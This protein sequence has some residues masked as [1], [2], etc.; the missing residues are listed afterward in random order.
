MARLA[1]PTIAELTSTYTSNSFNGFG[2]GI[3]SK[4][5][6][7]ADVAGTVTGVRIGV[8]DFGTDNYIEVQLFKRTTS[9]GV[10]T[11][12]GTG[13]TP[14]GTASPQ[15]ITLTITGDAT[16]SIGD[17]FCILQFGDV[18]A[19]D[20]GAT[21]RS[22]NDGSVAQ[23][24][25]GGLAGV[26]GALEGNPPATFDLDAIGT[27]TAGSF[28]MQV[29]GTAGSSD[30]T[31][32]S[33][34]FTDLTG[35]V[36][37]S[38]IESSVVTITGIDAATA[39]SISGD[40]SAEFR[41]ST[42]GGTT[43]G[44][45]TNVATTVEVND[46]VQLRLTSSASNVTSV[47]AVLDVGGVT[48]TWTVT[49]A[50][51][52]GDTTPDAF[53][54]TDV[55]DQTVSTQVESNVIVV[56]GIDTTTPISIS[57]TGTPEYR[58]S[59]DGGTTFGAYTSSAGNVEVNDQV[60]VRVTTSA[61]F[62]TAV[63]AALNIGGVIDTFSATTGAAPVYGV[64]ETLETL[65]SPG[66]FEPDKEYFFTVLDATTLAIVTGPTAQTT[67]SGVFTITGL[68]DAT[69]YIVVVVDDADGDNLSN[70]RAYRLTSA[71]IV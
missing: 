4:P 42:D 38:V 20:A 30:T 34:S 41:I 64:T 23:G 33:F 67:S 45:Y 21:W 6:F 58:I 1:G 7:I 25:D 66:T 69:E 28:W 17:E 18:S 39:I 61:S 5:E 26:D 24:A 11:L 54:F 55:T 71:E 68:S 48:D 22:A 53:T 62:S 40:A 63:D 65:G 57:G 36:V 56:T 49:T 31:P 10:F 51:A 35:Q 29:D 15:L 43:F 60:Q 70:T 9:S 50:A 19:T 8:N 16:C 2:S 52:S 37:S 59:T 13:N 47:D 3:T 44:S 27:E 14:T 46:Q 12:V 32:D